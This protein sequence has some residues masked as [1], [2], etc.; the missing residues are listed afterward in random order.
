M[1]MIFAFMG[2]SGCGKSTI[3]H[4][5]PIPFLT[6]YTT[7]GLRNGEIEGLHVHTV[8][9]EQF[10]KLD[11]RGKLFNKTEYAEN[12][13]G[14]PM[15]KITNMLNNNQPYH[16]TLDL[17][18]VLDYTG[19]LGDDRVCVIY[20]KAPSMS[21]LYS[22]MMVRG[23]KEEDIRRRI[24]NIEETREL[25]NIKYADY[26]VVNDDLDEAILEVHKIV[27][28]ELVKFIKRSK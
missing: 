2:A 23:D 18:G 26:V 27:I 24:K 4:S 3:Q 7:R 9:K 1:S 8:T 11:S 6:N 25:E 13:Y 14:S 16:A 28:N 21:E 19:K 17:N 22:R 20:V 15:E 10:L 5:L 12:F